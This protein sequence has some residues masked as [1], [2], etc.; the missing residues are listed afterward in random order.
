MKKLKQ[1]EFI[2]VY[3]GCCFFVCVFSN[4]KIVL[5]TKF[6]QLSFIINS[7]RIESEMTKA[8]HRA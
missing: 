4:R 3:H 6:M 7:F 1:T 8:R 5:N 2:S